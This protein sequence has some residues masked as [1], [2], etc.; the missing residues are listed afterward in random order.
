MPVPCR[1]CIVM[2]LFLM[3]ALSALQMLM[4]MSSVSFD[5]QKDPR[6]TRGGCIVYFHRR[7]RVEAGH[8]CSI[9]L[10]AESRCWGH[11]PQLGGSHGCSLAER[12]RSTDFMLPVWSSLTHYIP[13]CFSSRV[14]QI[15]RFV[16]LQ[17]LN[18]I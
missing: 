4:S 11:R 15:E 13:L 2:I 14:F 7:K 18:I 3:T 6:R 16:S 17:V 5:P 10:P 1:C 8:L 9:Y 12:D